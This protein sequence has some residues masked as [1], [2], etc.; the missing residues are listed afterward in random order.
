M[1]ENEEITI[2]NSQFKK[3]KKKNYWRRDKLINTHTLTKRKKGG[4]AYGKDSDV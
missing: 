3:K 4:M 2:Y 1:G